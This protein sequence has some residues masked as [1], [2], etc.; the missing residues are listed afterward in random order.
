MWAAYS[1]RAVRQY[2]YSEGQAGERL[3][4]TRQGQEV[5]SHCLQVVRLLGASLVTTDTGGEIT[6]WSRTDP[7]CDK[8]DIYY[9]TKLRQNTFLL[10]PGL[11]GPDWTVIYIFNFMELY[12]HYSYQ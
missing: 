6:V 1:D 3:E 5:S 11:T 12:Y 9:Q 7:H 4:L 2:S 8:S 10:P